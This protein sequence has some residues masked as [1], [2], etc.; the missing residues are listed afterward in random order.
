MHQKAF[1]IRHVWLKIYFL[2]HYDVNII[3]II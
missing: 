2:L 1:I 3:I